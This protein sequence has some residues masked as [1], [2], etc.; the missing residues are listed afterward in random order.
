[1][2]PRVSIWL[3]YSSREGCGHGGRDPHPQRA[4]LLRIERG[5]RARWQDLGLW[6]LRRHGEAMGAP[7][8]L[9][10]EASP[11]GAEVYVDDERVGTSS[12]E[13]KFKISSLSAGQHTVRL[14]LAGQRDYEQPLELVA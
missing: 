4:R 5:L 6:E 1:S 11:G 9:L 2:P 14:S 13:G 3:R 7:P 8:V 12:A 10:I